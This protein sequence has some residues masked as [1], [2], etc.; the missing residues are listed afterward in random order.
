MYPFSLCW[1][2]LH[3]L[4]WNELR[5]T[6][7]RNKCFEAFLFFNSFWEAVVN[8]NKFFVFWTEH[9]V[10]WFYVHVNYFVPVESQHVLEKGLPILVIKAFQIPAFL[11]CKLNGVVE[12]N[13][14]KNQYFVQ[15][16]S[17]FQAAADLCEAVFFYCT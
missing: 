2:E 11:H 7:K 15:R 6:M 16:R 1:E 10:F 4:S 9:D 3:H 12:N 13:E 17:T 14:I 5:S 8:E